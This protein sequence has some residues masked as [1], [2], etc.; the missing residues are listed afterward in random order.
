MFCDMDVLPVVQIGISR[1]LFTYSSPHEL[2][3]IFP[4][5]IPSLENHVDAP[6]DIDPPPLQRVSDHDQILDLCPNQEGIPSLGL[7]KN[8]GRINREP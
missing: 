1:T 2:R 6:V 8:S 4:L 7:E 3:S 5:G